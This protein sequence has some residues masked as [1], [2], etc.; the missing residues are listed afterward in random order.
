M[1]C[2]IGIKLSDLEVEGLKQKFLKDLN[3]EIKGKPKQIRGCSHPIAS[4]SA[5]FCPEC[6]KKAWVQNPDATPI[7]M[8]DICLQEFDLPT[9]DYFEPDSG[10]IGVGLLIDVAFSNE[11]VSYKTVKERI[12]RLLAEECDIVLPIN[13]RIEFWVE[14][15]I[16]CDGN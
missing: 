2:Y 14:P 8:D 16:R 1:A 15:C 3:D 7:K 6:G 9:L 11:K 13:D 10:E 12:R 5:N 4:A